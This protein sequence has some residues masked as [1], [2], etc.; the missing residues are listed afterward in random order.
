VSDGGAW[1]VPV[2]RDGDALR[3]A[4]ADLATATGWELKPE[5]LCRGSVCVP[6]RD[7]ALAR[8][9]VLDLHAF[10][11]A[12]RAPFVVDEVAGI[13]VLGTSVAERAAERAGMR[14]APEQRLLDLDG[15]VHHWSELG[16]KKKLLTAWA[17]W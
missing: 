9:G 12:L 6:L 16:R 1:T 13:A 3:T 15:N 4:V 5:G 11:A 2:A 10:A 7:G 17:S 8:D 14:V